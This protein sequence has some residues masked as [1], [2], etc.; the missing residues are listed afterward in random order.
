[1][2]TFQSLNL[3]IKI[4]DQISFF[5]FFQISFQPIFF[6]MAHFCLEISFFGVRKSDLILKII[7]LL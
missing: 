3:D 7:F 6:Q 5:F 4:C 2:I 1:M